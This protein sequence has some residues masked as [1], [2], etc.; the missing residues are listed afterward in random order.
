LALI[1]KNLFY[2]FLLFF[3]IAQNKLCREFSLKTQAQNEEE[4]KTKKK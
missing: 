2:V 1:E 3:I 4:E